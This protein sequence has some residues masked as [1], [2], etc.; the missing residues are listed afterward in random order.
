LAGDINGW[1]DKFAAESARGQH[2]GGRSVQPCPDPEQAGARQEHPHCLDD[3]RAWA[4]KR[5]VAHFRDSAFTDKDLAV[6]AYENAPA[7]FREPFDNTIAHMN[8]LV[9]EGVLRIE[10]VQREGNPDKTADIVSEMS[11]NLQRLVDAASAIIH[12]AE[13]VMD[14]AE[15]DDLLRP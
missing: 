6:L 10:E 15:I 3:V 8:D 12:G 2:G 11:R 7:R 13:R 4:P 1:S 9:A 5:Y 14:Q